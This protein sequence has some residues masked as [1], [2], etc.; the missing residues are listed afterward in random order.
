[1]VDGGVGRWL[2]LLSDALAALDPVE[3]D[4][5]L[6]GTARRVYRLP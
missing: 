2:T 6:S 5:V 4:A 3:R 1:M